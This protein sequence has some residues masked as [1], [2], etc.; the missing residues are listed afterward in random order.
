[1]FKLHAVSIVAVYG[2]QTRLAYITTLVGHTEVFQF[3]SLSEA[4]QSLPER[5]FIG[6]ERH[7]LSFRFRAFI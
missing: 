5:R 1:M 2:M 4:T 3:L 6:N 7:R